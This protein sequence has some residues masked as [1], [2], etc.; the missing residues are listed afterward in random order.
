MRVVAKLSKLN[1]LA[2]DE[3]IAVKHLQHA[4][5]IAAITWLAPMLLG[6]EEAVLLDR[7]PVCSMFREESISNIWY[8]YLVIHGNYDRTASSSATLLSISGTPRSWRSSSS[9]SL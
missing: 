2:L 3:E 9:F 6:R 8:D 4:L 7:R 1:N 5:K